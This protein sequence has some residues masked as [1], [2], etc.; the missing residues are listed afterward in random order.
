MHVHFL[1][2]ISFLML[3]WSV[4]LVNSM[5]VKVSCYFIFENV[6]DTF[7]YVCLQLSRTKDVLGELAKQHGGLW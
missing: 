5:F 7:V 3:C 1:L 4:L 6:S 2:S